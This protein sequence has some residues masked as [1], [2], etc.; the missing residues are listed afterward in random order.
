MGSDFSSEDLK[1]ALAA[2]R[3]GAW[4]WNPSSGGV[5][6]S[7]EA[8]ELLG[9]G[10]AEPPRTVEALL[11]LVHPDDRERLTETVRHAVV[12]RATQLGVEYRVERPCGGVVWLESFGQLRLDER[13]ELL[14]VVGAIRETTP[15]KLAE[16]ELHERGERL[17]LVSEL[18]SDYVYDSAMQG[19]T[20]V[21]RIVA[22]SFERTTGYS[23]E[24]IKDLGGWLAVIHPQDLPGL[25]SEQGP[26][27]AGTPFV[28]EYRIRSKDGSERW[29]RDRGHPIV[30]P[31]TGALERI[32]GGVQDITERKLLEAQ[33]LQAQKMEALARM[34]GSVAHDFNN[35][36]MI[37]SG[38]IESLEE[39]IGPETQASACVQEMQNA[40]EQ[41]T[42]LTRSLL[43]FG[44]AD[45]AAARVVDLRQ[46]LHRAEPMLRRAITGRVALQIQI[47]PGE[48]A[49]K[50]T[51]DP[52]QLR[53][54]LINL[55]INARDATGSEGTCRI[56]LRVERLAEDCPQRP[57]ELPHGL[58][59]R[60]DVSDT[61][62]GIAPADL[63]RIFE[64]YFSTKALGAGTG[65]GLAIVYAVASKH[66]GAV[67]V[68]T[69]Q[70]AGAG[71]TFSL[72][73][74][75]TNEPIAASVAP[76][77]RVRRAGTERVLVVEDDE[78]VRRSLSRALSI[79]GYHVTA[80]ASAREARALGRDA[81]LQH[82]A[83]I[84]D[85]HLASE[86]GVALA[87]ELREAHPE[88]RV[89]LVSGGASEAADS[90]GFRIVLKPFSPT[91]VAAALREVLDR[92]R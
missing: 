46:E 41:A 53:L 87:M 56:H 76:P 9:I 15:R 17:R 7:H 77:V 44:R 20:A 5:R 69:Q 23:I 70:G 31:Q 35:V 81:W 47:E 45:E 73:F 91:G 55:V 71:T 84:T 75:I 62:A 22:G 19:D 51:V 18:S 65:L 59:A 54:A 58:Y 85:V 16:L 12:S 63:P 21:P 67:T 1:A 27:R 10:A 61:G 39:L 6:W 13:G 88:L 52:G 49:P 83:L 40:I 50:V 86:N 25:L 66:H 38:S 33:L 42:E 90:S 43:S 74:P 32:V 64:P 29:L 34:A 2:A 24:D 36:L 3:V 92:A 30:H 57:P 26:L 14:E 82:A 79:H 11:A 68:R 8:R 72:F 60:I 37:M 28:V 48:A 80:C 78:S 89:L 4:S